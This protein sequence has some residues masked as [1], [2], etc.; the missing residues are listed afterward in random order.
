MYDVEIKFLQ[1][2]CVFVIVVM[3]VTF[4]KFVGGQLLYFMVTL[5]FQTD[6][7]SKLKQARKTKGIVNRAIDLLCPSKMSIFDKF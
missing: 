6:S 7:R 1:N 4:L 3:I 2:Y 5:E